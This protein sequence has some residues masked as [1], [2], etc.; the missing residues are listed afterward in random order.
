MRRSLAL[1][2]VS[3]VALLALG[4]SALAAIPRPVIS[5]VSPTQARIGQTL[6]LKG[7]NFAK[8]ARVYFRR[9]S[10]GK[11]VRA[12]AKSATKTRITVV[13]PSSLDQFLTV[14]ADGSKQPTRFQ[15]GI[16]TRTFGPYT[17]KSRSPLILPATSTPGA[18]GIGTGTSGPTLAPPPCPSP[19]PNADSD[20]DHLSNG[21]E[22]QIHTDPCKAD[23]DGDGVS[24]AY[25]YYSALDLNGNALPYPGSRPYPNPLDGTDAKKDFDGDG[26]TQ[27]EEYAAWVYAGQQLPGGPGQTFPY[28][29]GNQTS[30]APAHYA[31]VFTQCNSGPIL[32]NA[33]TFGN[34]MQSGDTVNG[35]AVPAWL[36]T[37]LLSYLNPD[38]DGD[39]ITDGADD[40]DFDGL[41]NIEEIS[42]GTDG[43]YTEPQDPCD[44][45][46]NARACPLHASAS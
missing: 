7:K 5:S 38:T 22:A 46:V 26:M 28:S 31:N 18:P 39:G 27:A 24:D 35:T 12:R 15:I 40:N 34:T 10:D 25:E 8:G 20:G 29:D 2:V 4:G 14:G 1:T 36:S 45:N 43:F 3:L 37:Q 32:P 42:A 33:N 16:F 19:D 44:P 23:T 6:T 11:T 9:A 21:L 17:R 41:S 30:P 13:V